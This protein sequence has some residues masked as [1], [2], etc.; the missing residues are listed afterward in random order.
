LEAIAE[1]PERDDETTSEVAPGVHSHAN[2]S[3]SSFSLI[4]RRSGHRLAADSSLETV[5]DRHAA[6]R[7]VLR[8]PA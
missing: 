6:P 5:R 8:K 7:V 4:P 2:S 1:L 3:F